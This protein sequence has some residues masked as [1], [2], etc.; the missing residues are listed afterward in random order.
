MNP[1]PDETNTT[2]AGAARRVVGMVFG[3]LLTIVFGLV[4]FLLGGLLQAV[5]RRRIH[6]LLFGFIGTA[7]FVAVWWS[8]WYRITI[9]DGHVV[10]ASMLLTFY[11]F[12]SFFAASGAFIRA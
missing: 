8:K 4:P 9:G 1:G 6:P 10:W 7:L 12:L 11:V 3:A 2:R 5:L